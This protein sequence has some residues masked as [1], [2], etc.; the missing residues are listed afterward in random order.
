MIAMGHENYFK[1]GI[2]LAASI[3]Q[4]S[5]DAHITIFT[6]VARTDNIHVF[7]EIKILTGIKPI[8][9]KTLLYT[10]SPYERTLYLDVDM[11]ILP[12]R[13][14][15]QLFS[16]LEN[17]SFQ[18]MNDC[19]GDE[20]SVWLAAD[21]IRK[22][23]KNTESLLPVYYSELIYFEKKPEVK[24]YFDRVSYLF[25]FSEEKGR[26]FG[27]GMADEL[28]FILASMEMR[29]FPTILNWLPIF[30][31]FRDKADTSQQSY[32][33]SEKYFGY[34]IGGN[35]YPE[36]VKA[37]Y[38]NLVAYYS[39]VMKVTKPFKARDKRLYLSNRSKI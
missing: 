28:A 4:N 25:N 39:K 7:D 22:I 13:D 38:N 32:K 1:M 17:T 16:Q 36:Y 10:I 24:E 2:N 33:L 34:S 23:T 19:K 30:W 21:S 12:G 3:K 14:I 37:E 9:A 20:Y 6:D 18:I 26:T 27:G 29:F 11:L 15:T 8:Q 35:V 31:F 5:P